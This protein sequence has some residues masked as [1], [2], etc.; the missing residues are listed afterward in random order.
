MIDLGEWEKEGE[1]EEGR[2]PTYRPGT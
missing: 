2:E 1:K